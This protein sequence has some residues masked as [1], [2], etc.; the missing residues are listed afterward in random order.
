MFNVQQPIVV[1]LLRL[2]VVD[3]GICADPQP[4]KDKVS[5]ADVVQGITAVATKSNE[6]AALEP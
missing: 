2:R 4:T 1:L 3:Q 5:W 6:N